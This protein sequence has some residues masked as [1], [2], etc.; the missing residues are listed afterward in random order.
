MGDMPHALVHLMRHGEVHNPEGILY[1][2]LPG[3]RLS[4]RGQEMA[5]VV[6]DHLR[7]TADIR[8]VIASPLQRA[9]ETAA[10]TAAAFGL[11]VGTDEALIE[12]GNEFEGEAVN[13]NRWALAHPRNWKRYLNPARPSWGEPYVEIADRMV[14]AI[15]RALDLVP[16]GGEVLL[17]SHQLPIWV[18]RLHLEGRPFL[19]DPRRRECALA[20]LTSLEFDD[21][22]LISLGYSEPTAELVAQSRDMV[23]GRSGASLHTREPGA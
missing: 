3:Y 11:S 9:R 18:T 1:G 17:V 7:E 10:P 4:D 2:R 6:A 5:R 16:D 23:P 19:H 21:R 22:R 13:A 15:R 8:A 14:G 20:S 12:A